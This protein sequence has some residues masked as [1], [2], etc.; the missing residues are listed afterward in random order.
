MIKYEKLYH[1]LF[2]AISDSIEA[3]ERDD[4]EA[5]YRILVG[6]QQMAEETYLQFE[7]EDDI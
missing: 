1:V 7:D 5:G 3:L 6:A 2:N 4:E